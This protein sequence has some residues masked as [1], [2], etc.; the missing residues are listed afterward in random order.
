MSW[1]PDTAH[2]LGIFVNSSEVSYRNRYVVFGEIR[3]DRMRCTDVVSGSWFL[4]Y[5]LIGIP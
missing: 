3:D 2:E 4:N 5:C 1:D